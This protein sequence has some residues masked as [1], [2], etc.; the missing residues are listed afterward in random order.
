MGYMG[1]GHVH[2]AKGINRDM[3]SNSNIHSKCN[4]LAAVIMTFQQTHTQ[5]Q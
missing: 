1:Q 2:L 5:E 4:I 3:R